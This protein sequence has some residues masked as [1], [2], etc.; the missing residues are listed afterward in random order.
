MLRNVCII[1]IV[2]SAAFTVLTLAR[3]IDNF[4]VHRL[5]VF[6]GFLVS[7]ATLLHTMHVHFRTRR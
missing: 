7:T 2:L 4:S 1:L 3:L 5:L 6:A